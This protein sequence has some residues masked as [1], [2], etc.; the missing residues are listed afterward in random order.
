[1]PREDPQGKA[2][3]DAISARVHEQ[4]RKTLGGPQLPQGTV[5][6]LFTDVEGSTDLVRELGDHGARAILRRHDEVVQTAITKH[7]GT[8]VERAGDSFMAAFITARQAVACAMDIQ[9]ALAAGRKKEAEAPIQVRIG[10]DTG[11][12]IAEENRYFGSTVFRAA[13]IADLAPAGR[14]LISEATKVL[15]SQ[16]GFEFE[17]LGEHELKGLGPGHR[18]YEVTTGP[19]GAG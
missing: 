10:M 4:L 19:E 6:I 14:I 7:E 16:A 8:E 13:R 15:A 3:S 12:I 17:D 18:L 1:M 11:E 5:T 2:L 9:Q